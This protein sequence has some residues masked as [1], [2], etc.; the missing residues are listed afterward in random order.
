MLKSLSLTARLTLYFTL[1]SALLVLGLGLLFTSL[2][3]RHFLELDRTVL[4]DKLDLISEI[5]RDAGS[6]EDARARLGEALSHHGGLHVLVRE[7]ARLTLYQSD[8]F[9]PPEDALAGR[10][11]GGRQVVLRWRYKDRT[12]HGQF[13]SVTP[14]YNPNS[15]HDV[16]V[17]V[18]T[19]NHARFMRDLR[20]NLLLYA[21][22][23]VPVSGLL[24]W[25]A[26]YKGVAPLRAMKV[27]ATTVSGQK[28]DTRMPLGAV[29]VEMADLALELNRMLDRLQDDFQRL[30]SFSADLAHE[31]RTPLN[32]LLTQTQVALASKRE[33]GF[34]RD[35]LA[36]NAEEFQ[37]LARMVS[38]MLYLA[39]TERGV[40]VPAPEYF[41]A[42]DE[43]R[44]LLEFYE[45]VASE[46]HVR[47]LQSG[48]GHLRADRLMFRRALSNLLSNALRHTDEQGEV[49]VRIDAAG[50]ALRVTVENTG[51]D[52]DPQVLPRLFDRFFRADPSRRHGDSDGTGLG[53]AI[54]RAIVEAHGGTATV[55]SAQGRTRFILAFPT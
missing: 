47:V 14:A 11:A 31:L 37:R 52:I 28:L 38:D 23:A 8:E 30:T 10:D 50:D 19:E 3:D 51:P 17:A 5:L 36:S 27:Q 6:V 9:Q 43:V 18:D 24:G 46:K 55:Q 22:L 15:A 20:R 44:A 40:D 39:K 13:L 7:G 35:I 16:I 54:T 29:P 41:A 53:L 42:A 25:L 12:L 33:A 4:R 48:G 49:S 2:A 45:P 32:N 34:Y 1:V 21:L 26:A